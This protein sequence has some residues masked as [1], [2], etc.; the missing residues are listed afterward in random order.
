AAA[1]KASCTADADCLP[2]A[3]CTGGFCGL[4]Q[5]GALCASKDECLSTFCEQ[6]VCCQTACTGICKS[7]ALS[8]SRGVCSNLAVGAADIM[9]RC[10]DQ[11][12]A[13]CGT[14]GFCD[15]KG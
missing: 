14:D 15:G 9:S 10:S 2:P 13:S 4:K 11:G 5:N 3:T 6:G 8:P 12:T 7:C 1:C